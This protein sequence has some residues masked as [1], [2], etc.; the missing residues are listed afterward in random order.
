MMITK[1]IEIN[2]YDCVAQRVQGWWCL[3]ASQRER[4]IG[5]TAS[6]ATKGGTICTDAYV[7]QCIAIYLYCSSWA[8][9][10]S[11]LIGWRECW[12]KFYPRATF[13]PNYERYWNN[14]LDGGGNNNGGGVVGTATVGYQVISGWM[15]SNRSSESVNMNRVVMYIS[16]DELHGSYSSA[17]F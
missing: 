7:L 9:A 15:S 6:S 8:R 17:C 3:A 2:M 16:H 11:H 5:K 12:L 13:W 4:R 14:E 10:R 1:N